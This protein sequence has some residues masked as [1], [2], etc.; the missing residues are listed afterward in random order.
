MFSINI[1]DEEVIYD[2]R[3]MITET[4]L[5]GQIVFMNRKFKEMSGFSSEEILGK[6]HSIVRHPDM[7]EKAFTCMWDTI[8]NGKSWSGFVKNLRKDGRF[9][10]V[11]V[12]VEPIKDSEESITGYCA[13]RRPVSEQ[14]KEF[15][16]EIFKKLESG[17]IDNLNLHRHAVQ[18]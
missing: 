1:V 2:G 14:N 3:P 17:E 8:K 16:T 10:W 5:K 4:D 13:S 7:P 6:P 12:T 18:R 15:A 9:Y 11:E